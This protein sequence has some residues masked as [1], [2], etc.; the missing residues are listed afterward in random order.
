MPPVA[1]T[2][3]RLP[4]TKKPWNSSPIYLVAWNN[5]GNV[6]H[7]QGRYEEAVTA[8]EKAIALNK[9]DAAPWVWLCLAYVEMGERRKAEDA[10]KKVEKRL[11]LVASML[12]EELSQRSEALV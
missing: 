10:V 6:H 8:Y 11:P 4:P 9:D 2:T 1:G 3:K 7:L 5:L 12:A